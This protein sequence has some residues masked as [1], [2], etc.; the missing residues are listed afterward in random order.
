MFGSNKKTSTKKTSNV[1]A[2][3]IIQP[4]RCAGCGKNLRSTKTNICGPKCAKNAA[5][6][7]DSVD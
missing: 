6:Q 2:R 5:L 4:G 3:S 7:W 1:R